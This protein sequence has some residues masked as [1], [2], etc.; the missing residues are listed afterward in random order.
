MAQVELT[1]AAREFMQR[2]SR[3]YTVYQAYGGG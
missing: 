3:C 2:R 1:P